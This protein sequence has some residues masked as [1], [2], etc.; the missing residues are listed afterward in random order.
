MAVSI[1][2]GVALDDT[3]C[4]LVNEG[5][6]HVTSLHTYYILPSFLRIILHFTPFHWV[7]SLDRPAGLTA[8]SSSA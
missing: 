1:K 5:I 4:L 7:M 3:T 8:S 6:P 2:T